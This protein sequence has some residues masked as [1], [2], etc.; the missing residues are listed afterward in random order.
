VKELF[1]FFVELWF[2]WVRDGGYTAVFFLMAMESSIF[3]V[4][5]EVVMPPAAY[6]AAQGKLSMA[7]VIFAGTA[8]SWFGS[9]VTYLVSRKWGLPVLISAG[10]RFG[11][12]EKKVHMAQTWASRF[13]LPGVFFARLLP[14]V[15]HLISIP[16]GLLSMPVIPFSIVTTVGA[17]IWCGVLS[18]YGAAVLGDAP[19]LLSSPDLLVATIKAKLLVLVATVFAFGAALLGVHFKLASK[20]VPAIKK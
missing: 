16:A 9:I 15:R 7:G 5:S 20:N 14:V 8:G 10:R 12:T 1:H 6:W 11:L 19:E 3:P 17:G 18:W 2:G 13:G 4:P